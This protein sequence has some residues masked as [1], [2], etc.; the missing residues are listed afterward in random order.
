VLFLIDKIDWQ[1]DSYM[2]NCDARNLTRRTKENY[3]QSLRLFIHY[4]KNEWI[5]KDAKNVKSDHVK[6]YIEFLRDRG[7]YTVFTTNS[8][9]NYPDRRTDHNKKV[10]DTTIAHYLRNIKVFLKYLEN[11]REVKS[12]P[13]KKIPNIKPHRGHKLPPDDHFVL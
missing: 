5:V 12:N 9:V 7:K 4:L 1:L 10:S 11:E 2:L 6:E 3:E 13:C 8:K